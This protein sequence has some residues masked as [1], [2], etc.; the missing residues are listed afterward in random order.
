MD[1]FKAVLF[2]ASI[3]L[4]ALSGAVTGERIEEQK[5][6]NIENYEH[7]RID[8]TKG[9]AL[10]VSARVEALSYPISVMLI[11]GDSEFE[12]FQEID[13]L[14]ADEIR[15]GNITDMDMTYQ[16]V[17]GFSKQN[18]TI[19]DETITI[20][21]HDTYYLVMILYRDA[22]MDPLEVLTSRATL[23]NYVVVWNVENKYVPYYLI[24]VAILFF[25]IG[26]GLLAYYF[27]PRGSGDDAAPSEMQ[28]PQR[29][30]QARGPTIRGPPPRRPRI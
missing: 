27:W 9:E 26:G 19:F 5:L 25:L 18:V 12:R 3:I 4:I 23:V 17:A 1:R 6:V 8:F 2:A 29:P 15:R 20:G 21:D 22:D 10:R 13:H 24:P 28:Y 11:K 16:V 30:A 14:E 7:I